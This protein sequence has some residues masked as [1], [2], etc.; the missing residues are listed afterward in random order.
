MKLKN[1]LPTLA[2]IVLLFCQTAC[3]Q[4]N[5]KGK[6]IHLT[7]EEFMA[8]VMNYQQNPDKWVYLGDKP[9]LIDFYATWCGPC[10]RLGPV[11]DELAAEYGDQIYIYKVDVDQERQLA[12]LFQVSSV[13]TLVFCPM[14]EN[15]QLAKGALPKDTLCEIIEKVL[16]K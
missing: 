7:N 1:L 6:V 8:K 12:A 3:A 11:L 2:A 10:K 13:P 15:P 14:G 16:L 5:T 9:C 4:E